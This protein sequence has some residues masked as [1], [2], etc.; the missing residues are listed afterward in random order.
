MQL[1]S[2]CQIKDTYTLD[3]IYNASK[4]DTGNQVGTYATRQK[5]VYDSLKSTY[6]TQIKLL[7]KML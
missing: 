4:S 3:N 6:Q 1:E 5:M 2:T 7:Q